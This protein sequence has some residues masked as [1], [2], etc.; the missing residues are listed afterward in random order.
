MSVLQSSSVVGLTACAH[1][2][3]ETDTS[4][5]CAFSLMH[6]RVRVILPPSHEREHWKR[7]KKTQV[8]K[9]NTVWI[10]PTSNSQHQQHGV[11]R[12]IVVPPNMS[13]VRAQQPTR[14][15]IEGAGKHNS[16]FPLGPAM[17]CLLLLWLL[18]L[19]GE[20]VDNLIQSVRIWATSF[21]L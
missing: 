4:I 5:P 17:T 18:P 7:D 12:S 8:W 2:A 13:W 11:T 1:W 15:S 14:A 16:L 19:L 21:R 20:M 9:G 6:L 10:L 3:D